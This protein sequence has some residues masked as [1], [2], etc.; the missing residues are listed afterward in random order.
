LENAIVPDIL[1]RIDGVR[2]GI[3]ELEGNGLS[4]VTNEGIR[5]Y[6]LALECSL[7]AL[8][9]D[10]PEMERLVSE[11]EGILTKVREQNDV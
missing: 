11:A 6:E 4:I 3:A 9:D 8:L 10:I 5:L 1:E 2:N 7:A